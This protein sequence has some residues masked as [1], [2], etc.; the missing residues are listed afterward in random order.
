M[1]IAW[2]FQIILNSWKNYLRPILGT[3]YEYD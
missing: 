2:Y 1:E 3:E